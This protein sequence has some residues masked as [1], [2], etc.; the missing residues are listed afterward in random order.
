MYC[1]PKI[2]TRVILPNQKKTTSFSKDSL[3]SFYTI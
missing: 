2:K 1:N 3:F